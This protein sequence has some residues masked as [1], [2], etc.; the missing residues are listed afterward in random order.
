MNKIYVMLGLLVV[1]AG[2]AWF[3]NY[4]PSGKGLERK[5]A[6]EVHDSKPPAI[7]QGRVHAIEISDSE[8]RVRVARSGDKW[9]L[10]EKFGA[11]AMDQ[12]A[13][14]L[15]KNLQGLEK[16]Q[17]VSKGAAS[18]RDKT[19]GLEPEV[20]KRVKL[21][22]ETN[23]IIVDLWVG[24]PDMSGERTVQLAGNFVRI[25]GL[26]AVYSHRQRLQHVVM[27]QLSMWLDGRLFPIEQKD[28]EQAV[29]G[30][31]RVTVEFDDVPVTPG[32][33]ETQP[34]TTRESAPR[35]RV[36]LE[37]KEADPVAESA[38]ADVGPKP[39]TTPPKPPPAKQKDW[40]LV[41]PIEPDVKPY[42]PFVDQILRTLLY[43]RADDVVSSDPSL[44]EFG[45]DRP[46]VEVEARFKDGVTRRLRIGNRAPP[47]TEP[48][49]RGGTYRYAHVDGVPRVFLVNEFV[50][51]QYRKK[52]ADLKQPDAGRAAV[53]GVPAPIELPK[54]E[55]ETRR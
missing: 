26:D 53:P 44:A 36:V 12:R 40:T 21:F 24:K 55:P 46:F 15:L 25:E 43:G 2:V 8:N 45:L 35:V 19:F 50:L 11:A 28:L 17:L 31:E 20:A 48:S 29:Q 27:P 22:D 7:D 1:L 42:T 6:V 49:R 32:V 37:G 38:P 51:A 10:P 41:E 13:T 39:A 5:P 33:A 4:D 23:K 30:A 14:E 52:P 9:V 47:P 16:A 54:E 18:V 3:V 34:A